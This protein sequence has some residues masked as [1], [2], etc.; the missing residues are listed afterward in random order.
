[1]LQSLREAAVKPTNETA[2]TYA[3]WQ[4]RCTLFGSKE[5]AL[6]AQKF[7]DT[8]DDRGKKG[9]NHDKAFQELLEAMKKDINA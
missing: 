6:A 8:N 7:L 1:L 4:A 2:K 9:G 5:V 3:L